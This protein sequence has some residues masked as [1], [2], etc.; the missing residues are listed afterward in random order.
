MK[1]EP[2]TPFRPARGG[3]LCKRALV[4]STLASLRRDSRSRVAAELWPDDR[5]LAELVEIKATS[6]PA[7]TS[8]TGWAKELAQ[9]ATID[10]VNALGAASGA[11][12]VMRQALL[13]NWNGA[14]I[15]S[16]PGFVASSSN[17]SFVQEGSPIPVRQ[18]ASAPAQLTPFKLATIAVLSREMVES[19]NAEA[20]I[21]D[22]LV[23]STALALDAVFFGTAAATAAQPA[24]I[25]N[26]ISTLTASSNTDP[27]G[28]VFEDIGALIGSV[29]AVGGKGPFILVG[30]PGRI[31]SMR[32]RFDPDADDNISYAMSTAVG[33]DLI[34][35]AAPAVVAAL[36]ADPDV[37]TA[38]TGTL[39]MDTAPQVAG[40]TGQSERGLYQTDSIATKVRWPASWALRDSRAVAWTTPG[41]K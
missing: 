8:V 7:M 32:M 20:L 16:A 18:L 28:A 35:V 17:S 23:R 21:A 11:A 15:I 22:A 14:G 9:Q 31:A 30:S 13:V 24:G 29:S 19:S 34:A 40:T 4:V 6:A 39:M 27:F 1:H 5:N 3:N 36:S 33:N 10:T 2:L 41:W 38:N 12:D 37:E 26:G 25:R